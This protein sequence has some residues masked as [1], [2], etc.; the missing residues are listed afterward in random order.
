MKTQ[1]LIILCILLGSIINIHAE[2]FIHIQQPVNQDNSINPTELSKKTYY[3]EVF[4]KK[5]R[6]ELK[7]ADKYIS[8]ADKY[9]ATYNKNIE[10]IERLNRIIEKT[11]SAKTK[12]KSLKKIKKLSSKAY[13]SA[14]K[15][16]NYY[17]KA[18]NSK[19]KIYNTAIGRIRLDDDS[20]NATFGRQFELQANDV[21]RKA[22]NLVGL[23]NTQT[24]SIKIKTLLKAKDETKHAVKLKALAI[25]NYKNDTSDNG[26]TVAK[27]E[28]TE[29]K[30]IADFEKLVTVTPNTYNPSKDKNLYRSKASL[31]IPKLNMNSADLET[32]RKT[33]NN[34]LKA[35]RLLKQV[36]NMY[37][38]IDS[39]HIAAELPDNV[40]ESEQIHNKAADK[41]MLAFGKLVQATKLYLEVN[42]TRYTL[43]NKY[44]TNTKKNQT[45]GKI[46]QAAKVENAAG[47]YYQKAKNNIALSKKTMSKPEQ[48]IQLMRANNRLLLAI[49]YQERAFCIY[50]SL[51]CEGVI[52]P[53]N[54]VSDLNDKKVDN[55]IAPKPRPSWKFESRN[56]YSQQKPKIVRYTTKKG[57]VFTVQVGI[58][59]GKLSAKKFGTVQPIIFD[60]FIS[61]PQRRFM[62]GE[63]RSIAAA[64]WALKKVKKLGYSDAYIVAIVA[65]R[66]ASFNKVKSKI[67]TNDAQ[68]KQTEKIE[69]NKLMGLKVEHKSD[70]IA[71]KGLPA[72][73]NNKYFVE[74]DNVTK[75]K[76]LLY[77]VQLGMFMKP[78]DV[79]K[80][81]K[82][83]NPILKEQIKGKGTRYMLGTF[84]TLATAQ[85][86]AQRI[87][88]SGYSG[89]Y[90]TSY[91]NGKRIELDLA[92]KLEA[93]QYAIMKPYEPNKT[94][95]NTKIK[96]VE[97]KTPTKPI[98]EQQVIVFGVQIG[99]YSKTLS[100][101]E[102]GQL[103]HEFSNRKINHKFNGKMNIYF[104][105][106]YDN[107]KEASYLNK[108]LKQEGHK[109]IFV[110]A[111]KGN[112]KIKITE[113]LK[114]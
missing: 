65:G 35:D 74:T 17:E 66:R 8:K 9:F 59:K 100:N 58:F 41:E 23:A 16:F 33:K 54:L 21:L 25:A 67:N 24:D 18:N 81:F 103:K 28:K 45:S 104:V 79:K 69:L 71:Q 97:Q 26:K 88:Q 60:K 34:Q 27:E 107:Y 38:S 87:K 19:I 92:K 52:L 109:G 6:K 72:T 22:D 30:D 3:E 95:E 73:E 13:R 55:A 10:A 40:Y 43:Y 75:T 70:K 32:V 14:F 50:L 64:E 53:D 91:Y 85:T 1:K 49:Q 42:T 108:K 44:L 39:L 36:D 111:F 12:K 106:Y 93:D 113:A 76:G 90:V 20:P 68:Y 96:T 94:K 86:E 4:N 78:I 11:K 51:Q 83:L 89:A 112:N 56:V 82:G 114:K 63:Y 102:I 62:L 61:N 101:S 47:V 7:K 48:Y 99:A 29:K 77:F 57:V 5:E 15:A 37:A 31:I 84:G 2:G 46:Q 80:Q 98:V 105:G 110:I